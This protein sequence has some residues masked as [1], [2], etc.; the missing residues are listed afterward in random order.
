MSDRAKKLYHSALL[1]LSVGLLFG[2]GYYVQKNSASFEKM[3]DINISLILLLISIHALN[4][5]LLGITHFY[6]LRKHQIFL[7]FKEWYGLCTVSELFNMLLPAKGGTAVRMMYINDKKNLPMRE[8]LSMG[9]AVVL[10][11]FSLLGIVGT[12]YCHFFLTKHN[13]VFVALES[14]FIALTISSFL[15]IFASEVITR[16]FKLER[17]YSPKKYLTDKKIVLV[18]LFCYLGMFILYPIKIY[19]SFKAIGIDIH[20]DDSFE[21]SL[22]LLATSFFQV[23][24]G[25]I[26]VKE[27]ATAYIAQQYGFQFEAALL[28]SLVDRAILLLFLF[29]FGAYFY[30]SL[31]LDSSLPKINWQRMGASSRIPLMKRLVKVR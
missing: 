15:L 22:I 17:K 18:A 2:L 20:F 13:I 5:L 12:I 10:T 30:W 11:G 6:P 25:N 31:F 26:G 7:K 9:L 19:L 1:L 8:F 4:Y 23:L 24:P 27:V 21:I 28:A 3:K 14:L 16:I 29:P